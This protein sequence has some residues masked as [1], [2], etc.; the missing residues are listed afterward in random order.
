MYTVTINSATTFPNLRLNGNNFI[1][2]AEIKESDFPEAP[3]S[4]VISDGD[5]ETTLENAE[6]VQAKQ[7][8]DEWWFIL[9]EIPAEELER[10]TMI[11]QIQ[12]LEELLDALM[13]GIEDA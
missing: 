4:A 3:F 9:R 8:G 1:S 7:Y 13:E 11:S 12:M 2:A 10:K 6:L 5:T